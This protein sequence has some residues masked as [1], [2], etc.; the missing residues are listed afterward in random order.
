MSCTMGRSMLVNAS[1]PNAASSHLGFMN[2]VNGGVEGLRDSE[3][4]VAR[5]RSAEVLNTPFSLG[6]VLIALKHMK[7][8]KSGG[9]DRVPMPGVRLRK[10]M[11]QRLG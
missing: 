4:F 8:K 2:G 3:A 9:L 7:N 5:M 6:E 1:N 11:V 10:Q